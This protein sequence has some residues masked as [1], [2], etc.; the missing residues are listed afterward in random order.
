M[1]FGQ[2]IEGEKVLDELEKVGTRNGTPTAKIVIEDCG[3][4]KKEP[5]K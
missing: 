3:E 2:V 5:A 1:V 4:V